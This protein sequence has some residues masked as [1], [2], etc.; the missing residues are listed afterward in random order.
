MRLGQGVE[1]AVEDGVHERRGQR[2]AGDVVGQRH[3]RQ[4]LHH[5]ERQPLMLADV[6]DHH[7]V[8]AGQ[9]RGS[10]RLGVE[11]QAAVRPVG[12]PG[13]EQLDGDGPAQLAIPA[14][15]HL[16]H[17][18]AAQDTAQFVPTVAE[19]PAR[20]NLHSISGPGAEIVSPLELR[21]D[22]ALLLPRCCGCR[23]QQTQE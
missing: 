23:R 14:L 8:P 15:T 5:D 4:A 6:V 13:I 20:C 11:P 21:L 17:R 7:D 2:P 22:P 12:H 1:D 10:A 18:P 3:P 16:G 9:P 19:N